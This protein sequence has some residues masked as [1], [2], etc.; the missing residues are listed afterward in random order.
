MVNHHE[1]HVIFQ[2]TEHQLQENTFH[3]FLH[4]SFFMKFLLNWE[5]PSI[6]SKLFTGSFCVVAHSRK[7]FAA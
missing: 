2:D 7:L 5:V 1:V 6:L 4:Y 3:H